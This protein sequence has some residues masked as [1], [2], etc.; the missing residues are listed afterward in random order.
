MINSVE[1]YMNNLDIVLFNYYHSSF[2]SLSLTA[3]QSVGIHL[4]R[5]QYKTHANAF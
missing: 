2:Q 5:L 3:K 1:D 4:F